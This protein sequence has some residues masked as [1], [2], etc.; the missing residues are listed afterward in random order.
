MANEQVAKKNRTQVVI[1]LI[2]LPLIVAFAVYSLI[3]LA[4]RDEMFKTTNRGQFVDPPL[5]ARELG[6][7][8]Q[9]GAPVDGSGTWWVWLATANCEAACE[10]ALAEIQGLRQGLHDQMDRVRQALVLGSLLS[11]PPPSGHHPSTPRFFSDG[12]RTLEEGIYLVD[13]MGNV[14]LKYQSNTHS[15]PIMED[16]VKLLG[17][18]EDA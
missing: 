11:S 9:A 10:R 16:L 4:G 14:I 8:D 3:W 7:R 6:L 5:L 12:E 1:L 2:T 18:P 13:P 17:L 15:Q